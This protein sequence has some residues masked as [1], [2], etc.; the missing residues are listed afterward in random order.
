MQDYKINSSRKLIEALSHYKVKCSK[1]GHV[2]ILVKQKWTICKVCGTKV[3]KSKK[4]EFEDKLR[5][6][7]KK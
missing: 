5:K 4:D 6:E 3:Y 2:I 1:C 7:M